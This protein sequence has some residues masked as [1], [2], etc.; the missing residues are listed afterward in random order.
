MAIFTEKFITAHFIDYKKTQIEVYYESDLGKTVAYHVPVVWSH[1]D[2]KDLLKLV[3]LE[4]LERK[5]DK[6]ARKAA[7]NSLETLEKTWQKRI[8]EQ[9]Q[10]VSDVDD[11]IKF[12]KE[13]SKEI[14][15]L[16]PLKV[17]ILALPEIKNADKKIK[18]K[19]QKAKNLWETV[20]IVGEVFD[21]K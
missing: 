13:N 12:L 17:K 8:E 3:S 16:F 1:P 19:I 4:S 5:W 18:D 11:L 2:L 6:G 9:T 15:H 21:G 14:K 7:S 20:G 10:P